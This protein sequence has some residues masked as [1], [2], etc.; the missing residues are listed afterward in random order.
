MLAV[1]CMYVHHGRRKFPALPV[2]TLAK[3][4][5]RVSA[6]MLAAPDSTAPRYTPAPQQRVT[7]A[8]QLSTQHLLM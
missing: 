5:L 3:C 2:V 1:G 4:G 8:L 6:A 7:L